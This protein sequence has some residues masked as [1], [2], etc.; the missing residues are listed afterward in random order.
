MNL[1]AVNDPPHG[2]HSYRRLTSEAVRLHCPMAARQCLLGASGFDAS[3]A[4]RVARETRGR[5]TLRRAP[6]ERPSA[7]YQVLRIQAPRR[8][9]T[10]RYRVEGSEQCAVTHSTG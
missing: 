1:D 10:A 3:L 4:P 9:G 5:E 6:R 8:R 2:E 7:S